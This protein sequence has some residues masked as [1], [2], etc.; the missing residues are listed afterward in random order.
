MMSMFHDSDENVKEMRG[1]SSN[2]RQKVDAHV[3]RLR[4]LSYKSLNFPIFW[5]HANVEIFPATL[6]IILKMIAIEL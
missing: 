4:I 1:D 6:F 2:I 5:T 3:F